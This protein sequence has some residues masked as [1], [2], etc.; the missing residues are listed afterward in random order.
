MFSK[1][2]AVL[3]GLLVF[4]VQVKDELRCHTNRD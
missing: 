2:L 4:G 1:S 3:I